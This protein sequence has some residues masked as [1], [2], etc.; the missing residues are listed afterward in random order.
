MIRMAKTEHVPDL[1]DGDRTN[2]AKRF[3]SRRAFVRVVR[4]LWG[5]K[6]IIPFI[7]CQTNL[8]VNPRA[9]KGRQK[10][11]VHLVGNVGQIPRPVRVGVIDHIR[12]RRWCARRTG[13]VA[14]RCNGPRLGT[15][16]NEKNKQARFK[17]T[18]TKDSSER[19]KGMRSLAQ[20][21]K[22]N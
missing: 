16:T 17:R 8:I 5:A 1:V 6:G 13:A 9:G 19:T 12:I 20:I 7:K 18:H 22:T 14:K 11:R 4:S 15:E 2:I 21:A 10:I 3:A